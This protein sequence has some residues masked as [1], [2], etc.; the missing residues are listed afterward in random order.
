MLPTA[1]AHRYGKM[2]VMLSTS[3]ILRYGKRVVKLPSACML[4]YDE[5]KLML[6]TGKEGDTVRTVGQCSF[7]GKDDDAVRTTF[8][9][10]LTR[11]WWW[12]G[13]LCCM[14]DQLM[15]HLKNIRW[16]WSDSKLGL[17]H[18]KK[19]WCSRKSF[20]TLFCDDESA[21]LS[22]ERLTMRWDN[23]ASERPSFLLGW[24]SRYVTRCHEDA[25]RRSFHTVFRKEESFPGKID[26]A[27]Q[28]R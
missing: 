23:K 16:D 12:S 13:W 2:V 9:H 14:K 7:T 21:N 1:C 8:N 22:A 27:V 19:C 28:S 6:P 25:V 26:D 3:F 18:H 24:N 10:I 4:G 5:G 11:I 20:Q 15:W 17:L